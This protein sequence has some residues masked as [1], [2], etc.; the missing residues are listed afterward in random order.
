VVLSENERRVLREYEGQF[1]AEDPEFA[2]SFDTG[3]QSQGH[4]RLGTGGRCALA[5]AFLL[6]AL[7]V[8]IGEAPGAVT[9]AITTGVTWFVWWCSETSSPPN[10]RGPVRPDRNGR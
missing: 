4:A 8:V 5:V 9:V 6:S 2:S 3:L 7:L 1:K 10:D